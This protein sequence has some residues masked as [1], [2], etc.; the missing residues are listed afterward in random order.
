MTAQPRA[1]Q[2]LLLL[3][4]SSGR[5]A[6]HSALVSFLRRRRATYSAAPAAAAA[7]AAKDWCRDFGFSR[8]SHDVRNDLLDAATGANAQAMALP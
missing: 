4:S 5:S 1:R 2:L 3:H 6:S 7:A 8:L